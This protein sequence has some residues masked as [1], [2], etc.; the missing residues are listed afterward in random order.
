[1]PRAPNLRNLRVIELQLN[2][3][4]K[5]KSDVVE[6][7]ADYAATPTLTFTSQTGFNHDFLY[8]TEDYNRFSTT[9]GVIGNFRGC[10]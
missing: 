5:A 6:L 7:N 3:S 8:S 10:H 4:Y 1:M 2:P 9:P